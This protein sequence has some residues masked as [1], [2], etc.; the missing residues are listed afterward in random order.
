MDRHHSFFMGA[1]SAAI[2]ISA[3]LHA[4][5]NDFAPTV[6]A[7]RCQRVDGTFETIEIMRDPIHDDLDRSI[8]FVSANF[9]W[10]HNPSSSYWCLTATRYL[11]VRLRELQP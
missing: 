6:L 2:N 10:I 3:R 9:T 4:V 7:L 11:C 5:A 1:M 8:I